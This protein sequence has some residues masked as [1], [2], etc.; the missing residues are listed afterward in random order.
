MQTG[1]LWLTRTIAMV[2]NM[3]Q[4]LLYG[5]GEFP[6]VSVENYRELQ[7]ANKEKDQQII[8]IYPQVQG[9]VERIE[10]SE[11]GKLAYAKVLSPHHNFIVRKVASGA[12][13]LAKSKETLM[14]ESGAS[15][16]EIMRLMSIASSTIQLYV[17]NVFQA[18][19]S[20]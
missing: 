10:I 7:R 4:Y 5:K 16:D 1:L 9:E 3:M 14:R 18:L 2:M 19:G 6:N 11:A 12:F 8:E 20:N 13:S 17:D 15:E